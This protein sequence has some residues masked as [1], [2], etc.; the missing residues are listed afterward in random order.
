M[1][2]LNLYSSS[3]IED[4]SHDMDINENYRHHNHNANSNNNRNYRNQ[5]NTNNN[6]K[7]VTFDDIRLELEQLPICDKNRMV[8]DIDAEWVKDTLTAM[9]RNG[10]LIK[11]DVL[12]Y[13]KI[14]K[15]ETRP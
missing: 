2:T 8:C 13:T 11:A 4:E 5:H 10:F 9:T 15:Q 1:A 14:S 7:Y 6:K 12:S 3:E